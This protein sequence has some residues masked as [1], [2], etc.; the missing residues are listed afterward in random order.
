MLLRVY[1]FFCGMITAMILMAY[2]A[3][4]DYRAAIIDDG[5]HPEFLD[6][7]KLCNNGHYDFYLKR[8]KLSIPASAHG[9]LVAL[10][11]ASLISKEKKGCFL[12][13]NIFGDT[14]VAFR[15]PLAIDKAVQSGATHINL[16]IEGPNVP[17]APLAKAIQNAVKKKIHVFVAAGNMGLNLNEECRSFPT[18]HRIYSPYLHI[19]G[20]LD[21]YGNK[22]FYS[23]YG[24][25]VTEWFPGD[26]GKI[27]GTSFASPR[28]MGFHIQYGGK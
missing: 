11:A 13:Y 22:A 17:Y 5:F 3:K 4:A 6:R 25:L 26:M 21:I 12:I 28:A 10:A 18:C 9:S 2:S 19:V 8:P 20:A 14:N 23:N 24:D 7:V 27:W 15:A 16:S 1:W